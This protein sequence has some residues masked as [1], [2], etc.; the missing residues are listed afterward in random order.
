MLL[1]KSRKSLLYNTT[2]NAQ[3]SVAHTISRQ[4]YT[5][6]CLVVTEWQ[7]K[8]VSYHTWCYMTNHEGHS[9]QHGPSFLIP[10]SLSLVL[11][12]PEIVG[13]TRSLGTTVAQLNIKAA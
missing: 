2:Q 9:H 3:V 13:H 10:H 5:F 1:S 12:A 6:I 8:R 4:P 7:L 11:I